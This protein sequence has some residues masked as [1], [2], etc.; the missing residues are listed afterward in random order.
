MTLTY[1]LGV[2]IGQN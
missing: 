1:V 2:G